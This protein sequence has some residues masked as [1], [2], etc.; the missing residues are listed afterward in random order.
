[1]EEFFARLGVPKHWWAKYMMQI[2]HTFVFGLIMYSMVCKTTRYVRYSQGV[3]SMDTKVIK[4]LIMGQQWKMSQSTRVSTD[5]MVF[6]QAEIM[7]SS[8]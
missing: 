2:P 4:L 1:M 5:D 7:K 8:L 3:A 6:S